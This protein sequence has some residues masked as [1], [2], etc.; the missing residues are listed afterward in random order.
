[1]V[2]IHS[3]GDRVISLGGRDPG[4]RHEYPEGVVVTDPEGNEFCA[5]QQYY[6]K[7]DASHAIATKGVVVH[8]HSSS[9]RSRSRMSTT[10]P[11]G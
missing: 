4:K 9:R 5:V 8:R 7:R 6:D 3:M 10:E 1:M 2:D 11:A